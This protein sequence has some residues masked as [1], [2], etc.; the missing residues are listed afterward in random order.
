MRPGGGSAA[1]Q[2]RAV[3]RSTRVALDCRPRRRWAVLALGVA[4]SLGACERRTG[5]APTLLEMAALDDVKASG[6]RLMSAPM[7][8]HRLDTTHPAPSHVVIG[9]HGFESQG[10]EWIDPLRALGNA[11]ARVYFFRWDHTQCPGPAADKLTLAMDTML[12]N[13]A[14]PARVQVMGHSYGGVVAALVAAQ[15]TRAG[16]LEVETIAAPLAG[17]GGIVEHCGYRGAPPPAANSTLRQWRTR[18]ELDGAF[19]DLPTD[20]QVVDLPGEVTVLPET[21]RGKRLGHN[22][23]V[24]WVVEHLIANPG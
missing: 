13:E 20:P 21:Y 10:Y 11:G 22:W 23:S 9:V 4:L 12:K 6:L 24:S 18:Q 5:S 1:I 8:L 14:M 19:R 16:R 7:G 17:M 3:S 2:L 15:H